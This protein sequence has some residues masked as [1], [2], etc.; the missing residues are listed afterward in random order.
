MPV[1]HARRARVTRWHTRDRSTCAHTPYQDDPDLRF[2]FNRDQYT[3]FQDDRHTCARR[4]SPNFFNCDHT[5]TLCT[6]PRKHYNTISSSLLLFK[7]LPC[8]IT[9]S[10]FSLLLLTNT[11]ILAFSA[12]LLQLHIHFQAFSHLVNFLPTLLDFRKSATPPEKL[13]N[14]QLHKFKIQ[15]HTHSLSTIAELAAPSSLPRFF[16]YPGENEYTQHTQSQS[17]LSN[18]QIFHFLIYWLTSLT[19]AVKCQKV[20]Q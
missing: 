5:Q 14:L 13:T 6:S 16:L 20:S 3:Q 7:S 4:S 8:S 10:T 15:I 9:E 1:I 19:L 18:S 17:C 2:R 11:F 12:P